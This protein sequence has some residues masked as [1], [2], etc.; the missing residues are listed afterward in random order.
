MA[1]KEGF[2]KRPG[3]VWLLQHVT[4][5]K[6]ECLVWPFACVTPGYGAFCIGR[7]HLTTH[8]WMCEVT[9]GPPPSDDHE[10]AHSCGNRRCVNP[11]HLSWK[12]RA[13]NQLDRRL[14]GT[15]A[16]KRSKI[17]ATQAAQ[18]RQ[19]KGVETSIATAAR[20][21]ITESNVRHIQAG[22]TWK[23]ERKISMALSDDQVRSIRN[24]GYTMTAKEISASLGLR[25]GVI[26]RVRL[27]QYYKHVSS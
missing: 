8:R 17:N 23:A 21:G 27:G 15:A 9:N 26:N 10:A 13:S 16:I 19:L 1:K 4:Y 6:D 5:D 2:I 12:T 20:Y 22:N 18:I 24:I 7:K 11:K 3:H 25:I 14:H